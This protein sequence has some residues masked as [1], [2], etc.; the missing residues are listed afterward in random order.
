MPQIPVSPLAPTDEGYAAVF[1]SWVAQ[2]R[3]RYVEMQA[4]GWLREALFPDGGDNPTFVLV[5]SSPG[6]STA[7]LSSGITGYG[8]VMATV[9]RSRP[10][11]GS[12]PKD[13]V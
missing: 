11:R 3:A 7:D 13:P 2:G 10:P 12:L 6:T 1:N 5:C 9:Q 8:R 4:E